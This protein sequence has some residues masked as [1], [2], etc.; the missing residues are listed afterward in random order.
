MKRGD[1]EAAM[2]AAPNTLEGEI[3]IGGQEHFYL[4]T[5]AHIAIPTGEDGEME[6]ISST[7]NPTDT[8]MVLARVLGVSA[9]KVVVRVKRIGGGF[10]G[11]ESRTTSISAPV[12]VAA[13]M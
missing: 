7:Q 8:Q 11:K 12:A 3:H 9:N 10:G 13:S 4:E 6:V 5:N 1:V 2:K